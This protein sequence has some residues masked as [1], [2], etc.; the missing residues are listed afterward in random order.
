[1]ETCFHNH[2]LKSTMGISRF[3]KIQAIWISVFYSNSV[4][5]NLDFQ[6]MFLLLF[7]IAGLIFAAPDPRPIPNDLFRYSHG[8]FLCY[9][10]DEEAGEDVN[11]N[12]PEVVIGGPSAYAVQGKYADKPGFYNSK[13]ETRLCYLL[14]NATDPNDSGASVS[15]ALYTINGENIKNSIADRLAGAL[16]YT[17]VRQDDYCYWEQNW[18]WDKIK[19]AVSDFINDPGSGVDIDKLVPPYKLSWAWNFGAHYNGTYQTQ[20]NYTRTIH[21]EDEVLASSSLLLSIAALLSFVFLL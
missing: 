8:Q 19:S 1:M 16:S 21:F 20:F 11:S 10:F 14:L 6:P 5:K 15:Y 3:T 12:P 13:D 2:P 4:P 7:A 9:Y 18:D 17:L